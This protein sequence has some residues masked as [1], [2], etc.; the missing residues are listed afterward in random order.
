MTVKFVVWDK[1]KQQPATTEYIGFYLSSAGVLYPAEPDARMGK[2][3]N[4]E[5]Y[6]IIRQNDERT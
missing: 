6:T 2:D 5:R 3:L 1:L 4:P